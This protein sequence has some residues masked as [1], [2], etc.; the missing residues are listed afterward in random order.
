[1][2]DP[3]RNTHAKYFKV[4]V[5]IADNYADNWNRTTQTNICFFLI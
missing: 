3:T 1:M 5:T 4:S 2:T